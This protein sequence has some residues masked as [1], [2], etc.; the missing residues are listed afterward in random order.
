VLNSYRAIAVNITL[1]FTASGCGNADF[2]VLSAVFPPDELATLCQLVSTPVYVR[3]LGLEEVW[4]LGASGI[5][6]INDEV[7]G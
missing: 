2:L 7:A 3:G 5:D 4:A 1:H 6:E